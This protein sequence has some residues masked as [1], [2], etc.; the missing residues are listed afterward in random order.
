MSKPIRFQ[1][2]A[3][4]PHQLRAI[5]RTSSVLAVGAYFDLL[6]TTRGDQS[7]L[8]LSDKGMVKTI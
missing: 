2:D 4:Q 6:N 8:R 7:K 3:S 1:F 5:E